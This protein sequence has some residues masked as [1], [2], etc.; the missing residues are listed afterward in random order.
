M[1]AGSFTLFASFAPFHTAAQE[2]TAVL[3]PI[4]PVAWPTNPLELPGHGA[5][6]LVVLS[7]TV[8]ELG[9]VLQKAPD[10]APVP[11]WD[12]ATTLP[13]ASDFEVLANGG[14]IEVKSVGFKR[15]PIYAPLKN[16]DLR[17]GNW[18]YLELAQ[19]L[20]DG[21]RVEVKAAKHFPN[22]AKFEAATEPS[23]ISPVIHI[24]D[25]GFEP[26]WPKI[27]FAGYY[28]GSLGELPLDAAKSFSIID[29]AGKSVFQGQLSPRPDQG[30]ASKPYQNVLQADFSAFKIP[31]TYRLRIPS[32]GT[33]RPFRI[34]TGAIGMLARTYAV[35]LYNER[36]GVGA[37]LPF[38]RH[39]YGPDHTA[40]A[41]V[42]TNDFSAVNKTLEKMSQTRETQTAPRL[43]DV[44]SSLYPFV[45]S[46]KID[47]SG[48]HHDAGDYSVYTINSSRLISQL[49]FAADVFTGAGDL[50]NLGL[51]ESGDGKSDLLQEA[52]WEADYLLKMQDDDGGF[53]FLKYPRDRTYELDVLPDHGDPQVVF[54][55]NTAATA[56]ATA[57]LAQMA[58]SPRFK[59]QYPEAAARYRESALKG[60]QFLEAAVAKYGRKGAYQRVSHYGDSFGHD[61]ELIW[62]AVEM[63]LLT[64]DAKIQNQ[65]LADFDPTAQSAKLWNWLRLHEAYGSALRSYAFGPQSGRIKEA[66]MNAK[67]LSASR[68]EVLACAQEQAERAQASAYGTSFP[69]E[70]KRHNTAGWYFSSA[71]TLDLAAGYMLEP[72]PELVKAILT[73]FDF[74]WGAN[75]QNVA[76]IT[77]VGDNRQRDIVNQYAQND[78]RILPPSGI[79]LGNIIGGFA[80]LDRYKRELGT[81]TF[82]SFGDPKTP[83]A[84]MDRWSDSFNA[85]AESAVPTMA[86]A[87]S[88][89]AFLMGQNSLKT[90][91]WRTV[92][93]RITG[94]PAQLKVGETVT[95]GFAAPG[96]DVSQA[97]IVWEARGLEPV[98]GQ[99]FTYKSERN[100]PFWVE[101][102][103]L[104][105]DGRRVAAAA[106]F[107]ITPT[108]GGQPQVKVAETLALLNFDD[109][110]LSDTLKPFQAAVTGNPETSAENIAWMESPRGKAV[111]F[112]TPM[113][114]VDIPVGPLP[115]NFTLSGRLYLEP[116]KTGLASGGVLALG[117][118]QNNAYILGLVLHKYPTAPFPELRIGNDV[119]ISS[120]ELQKLAS[121]E[122][123]QKW[124]FTLRGDRV[125][126][127]LDGK[128]IYDEALKNPVAIKNRLRDAR[129]NLGHAASWVDDVTLTAATPGTP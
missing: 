48:G 54:P 124:D 113:A 55:K 109:P 77:G 46:G 76:F 63:F 105:P 74:E 90:Q 102:E 79:Q 26:D 62:A 123:W 93:A 82:P 17:L 23:R 32:L 3:E 96:L 97:E 30:W 92:D 71:N 57:C 116:I 56:A 122:T 112:P 37:S 49:C 69:L 44:K 89:A 119:V 103:G 85:Y 7:P 27:A 60:W 95:L 28:L 117:T 70:S 47:V 78:R 13:P 72:R 100:G 16:R 101:A 81:L 67:L 129:L 19:P 111:H 42:P 25:K 52:K 20:P 84:Q 31:G 68:A 107:P 127:V 114:G 99:R 50:D 45:K 12:F 38:S 64:G 75:P 94:V 15:I 9:L 5:H 65:W 106:E 66:A 61:D 51:P 125:K 10:P 33:S 22:G 53:F 2:N 73:N 87:L 34:G 29:G 40:P 121:L 36:C 39:V 83:Y 108:N 110:T 126:V 8:L 120:A 1:L 24:S 41:D 14:K 128:T 98:K 91:P 59:A 11:A 118:S 104:W 88:G 115:E 80:Y 4:V 86:A 58:S 6:R 35:G 43:V 18:L 21:A